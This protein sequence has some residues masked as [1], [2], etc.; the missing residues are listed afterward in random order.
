GSPTP[1]VPHSVH[2]PPHTRCIPLPR[3]RGRD[4]EGAHNK[5]RAG[6]PLPN[7]PPQAGEGEHRDRGDER[8]VVP[9]PPLIPA[10]AFAGVNSS[11]NP[12]VAVRGSGFPAFAGTNG[13]N[14]FG[15][16]RMELF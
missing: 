5:I 12:G 8:R 7:P 15:G 10:P 1:F 13:W 3:L 2:F 11:G 14:Y 4:R 6:H 9:S 16:E